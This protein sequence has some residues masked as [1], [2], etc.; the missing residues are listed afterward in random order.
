M[1]TPNQAAAQP[2]PERSRRHPLLRLFESPDR[3]LEAIVAAEV[4]A[5]P[6]A[7]RQGPTSLDRRA[8]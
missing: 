4:L 5:P 3:L 6:L 7:S 1:E 2:P 8:F